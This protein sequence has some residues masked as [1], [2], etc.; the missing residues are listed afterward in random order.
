MD[1]GGGTAA[2]L[3]PWHEQPA[4]SGFADRA[5]GGFAPGDT[6]QRGELQPALAADGSGLPHDIWQGLDSAR[7]PVLIEPLSIPAGSAT[8]ADL[9]RRLWTADGQPGG[10]PHASNGASG[11]APPFD[12]IRIEALYRSG[13]ISELANVLTA[14]QSSDGG[15]PDPVLTLLLAR[16]RIA[17]GDSAGGCPGIKSLQW[18][19]SSL[20]KP[21]RHEFLILAALCG[22]GTRDPAAASLAAEL[23][24]AEGVEA[25]NV[26]AALDAVAMGGDARIELP[27][28]KRIGLI[29]YR[30]L[31]LGPTSRLPALV[32]SAEP[33]LLAVLASSDSDPAARVAAA[34]AAL[35]IH[36]TA[37]ADL[38]ASY[39]AY[40][41]PGNALDDPS[42]QRLEPSLRRALMLQAIDAER[43]PARKA[44]L[45][46]DLLDDVRRSHGPYLQTA[47]MLAPVIGEL[48]PTPEFDWFAETAIEIHLAARRYE[49]VRSWANSTAAGRHR[50][51]EH[52]IVLAD[53]ADAGWQGRR[54]E[55]L[56]VVEQMA[57]R[58]S[59]APDLM[60]RLVT[61]LDALDYQI[62][63]P[64]WE[65]ASRSAQ[66]TTGHLPAT[67]V[68][69]EL[70]T[71]S[72][73][74]E[75][76][77]TVLFALRTLGPDSAA[78]ANLISIGDTIRALKRAGLVEDARRL[79]LEALFD[80]WPRSAGDKRP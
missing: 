73:Q 78:T 72:K 24:R 1:P 14:R 36:A 60:H 63:I 31:E 46:R 68:L 13:L 55:S 67:G 56:H 54:G 49:A 66:P 64:L 28:P 52:W 76:A 6:I 74:K 33:A 11:P 53:I 47:A 12:A 62:P 21:A 48:Q 57:V 27:S 20:P 41:F 51:L 7:L 80:S 39:R 5:P 9:W 61:V 26:L 25:P 44:R 38:A 40:R 69:S 34:E 65:S 8:L 71:A 43:A 18:K 59:L 75:H 19:Q 42:G 35:S 17:I 50:G 58:G 45:T 32:G 79:G 30:F 15:G 23:L 29:D 4:G 3:R 77:R 37:S 10:R 70:Q 16:T 2:P 22:A